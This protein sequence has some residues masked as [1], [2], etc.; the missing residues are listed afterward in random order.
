MGAPQTSGT[1]LMPGIAAES[2][3]IERRLVLRK[4]LIEHFNCLIR[5]IA[6]SVGF[7][8]HD[9]AHNRKHYHTPG[10]MNAYLKID[11]L[12]GKL[13]Q[14]VMEYSNSMLLDYKKTMMKIPENRVPET[15]QSQI[16]PLIKTLMLGDLEHKRIADIGCC[17][18]QADRPLCQEFPAVHWDMMD[19]PPN[20]KEEN[21]DIAL[22]NMTFISGYPLEYLEKSTTMYDIVVFNRTLGLIGLEQVHAYLKVLKDKTRFIVFG[23]ACKILFESGNLDVDEIPENAPRSYKSFLVHNYRKLFESAGYRLLHYD[24]QLS[25]QVNATPLYYMIRGVAHA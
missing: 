13:L 1:A 8:R 12:G 23:E 2:F 21:R 15:V 17:Y 19:F 22:D 24:G 25:T 3:H 7:D 10:E 11:R 20:L 16:M 9:W 4:P 14:E 18:V 6:S 5:D